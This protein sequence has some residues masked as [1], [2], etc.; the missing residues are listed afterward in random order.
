MI[1]HVGT[2]NELNKG[3]IL[4]AN[5]SDVTPPVYLDKIT[6]VSIST[7]RSNVGY[8]RFNSLRTGNCVSLL[9]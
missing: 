7:T 4:S 1:I 5:T 8:W 2:G 3:N 9:L 6:V